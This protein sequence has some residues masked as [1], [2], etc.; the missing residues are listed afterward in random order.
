M[1]KIVVHEKKKSFFSKKKI[2]TLLIGGFLILLM[3]MSVLNMGGDEKE[4]YEYKGVKFTKVDT[5]WVG[6]KGDVPIL[7]MNSPEDVLDVKV[8]GSNFKTIN[9]GSKI[10][11]SLNP[12]DYVNDG[13]SELSRN[14]KLNPPVVQACF[15]DFKGCEELPIKDCDDA[16]F[17]VSVMIFREGEENSVKFKNNCLIV[18]A[19]EGNMTKVVDRLILEWHE[20]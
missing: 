14:I 12:E 8:E 4:V 5:G 19:G 13:L 2:F 10:Y 17:F 11:L 15:E 6:Y 7:L 3:V 20:L 1:K 16:E 18:E 9:E